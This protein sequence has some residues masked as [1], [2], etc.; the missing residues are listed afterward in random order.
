[1]TK[2]TQ[3]INRRHALAGGAAAVAAPFMIG[4][5]AAATK[6]TWKVQSHWP[7]A[8]SSF[9]DSLMIIAEELKKNTDG[10][11]ELQ[12]FG[13]GEFAKGREIFNIVRRGVVEMG[14]I[15]PGYILGEAPTAGIALGVPGTFREAW[16]FSHFLK[17]MGFEDL[18]NE[19]LAAHG[20]VSRAEKIYP[21]EL[22][23]SKPIN[24]L[25]DFS[26]LKLRSSGSYLKFLEAAGAS[27]QNIAGPELYSSLASGVV[28]G[29]HW[30]AAQG[31]LSMSLW[32]VA[33]YHMKPT[34]GLAVDTLIMNQ[35]A[36]DDLPA[37]LRSEFFN[38]L[39]MRFWKRTAEYQYKEK[40]ALTKGLKEQNITIAQFPPDVL[41]KFS[42]AS[43][44]ILAEESAKGGNATKAADL[45]VSF[46]KGMGYV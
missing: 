38:L 9:G 45:L 16:E 13:A 11:F 22:V 20:V 28:D 17:N 21:T 30:G 6:V 2:T 15:S 27:T 12:L 24:S 46:L 18:F 23:V 41:E 29:A 25:A 37:D 19:D 3:G 32:E 35:K 39:D 1:M 44:A 8:S 4:K 5:A 26:S 40:L 33:K 34:M 42:E 31:A 7:K 36:I 10:Q 14:T 43:S